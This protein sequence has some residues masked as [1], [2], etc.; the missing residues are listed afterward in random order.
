MAPDLDTAVRISND[1]APEHLLLQLREPRRWLAL[2]RNAGSIFLGP[3]SPEPIGDYC[4]GTNHVLPT[5]GHARAV[6]GLTVS[7]FVK[8]ISVQE[9]TS[10]G[11]RALGPTAITLAELEGLDG[12]AQAVRRRL[13]VLG[14]P[15]EATTPLNIPA[16]ALS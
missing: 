13:Q 15:T 5:Y 8:S 1:Y 14:S 6:S 12:H 4:S 10:A 2:V 3:W 11:L 16:Q 7:D 9:L